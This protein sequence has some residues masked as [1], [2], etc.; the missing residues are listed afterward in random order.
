MFIVDHMQNKSEYKEENWNSS[1]SQQQAVNIL[2]FSLLNFFPVLHTPLTNKGHILNLRLKMS[3]FGSLN[4][5]LMIFIPVNT[6]SMTKHKI[7]LLVLFI[8][9][10]WTLLPW[11][12]FSGRDVKMVK[13]QKIQILL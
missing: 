6:R 12:V 3:N 4:N 9:M 13:K 8:A 2:V 5:H 7:L 11:A 10:A 1:D